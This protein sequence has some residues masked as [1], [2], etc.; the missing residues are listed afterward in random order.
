VKTANSIFTVTLNVDPK[1]LGPN[2][3]TATVIDNSIKTPTTN[4]GVSL[5][6][7]MLDMD[8]GT[9]TLNLQPDGKG[10]CSATAY[11]GMQGNYRCVF[12][13]G[14]LIPDFMKQKSIYSCRCATF[15]RSTTSCVHPGSTYAR[16]RSLCAAENSLQ[17]ILTAK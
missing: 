9:D 11:L 8:I 4:V 6:V 17:P 2:V 12:R 10:H 3:F 15:V 16:L 5:Y 1:R 7:T 13:Y 14:R